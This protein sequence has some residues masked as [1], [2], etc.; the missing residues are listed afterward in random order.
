MCW[1]AKSVR[2]HE[3]RQAK[4]GQ[5]MQRLVNP[6][7][8][9]EPGMFERH[10]EPRGDQAL[11]AIDD[12]VNHEIDHGKE[13]ESRCDEQDQRQ[14]HRQMYQAMRQQ[15]QRPADL[16]ILAER[17]P[18]IL[19]HEIGDDVLEGENEHPSDQRAHGNRG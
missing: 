15:G 1:F 12:D 9:P 8:R 18:G 11:G 4:T 6:D 17:H 14:R 5:V 3:D 16:L 10:V 13:P 19:Q 7:Q 2:G